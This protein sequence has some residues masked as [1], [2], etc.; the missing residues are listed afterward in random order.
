MT[1]NESGHCMYDNASGKPIAIFI[2][3]RNTS[4][5]ECSSSFS[6]FLLLINTENAMI[7]KQIVTTIGSCRAIHIL[8]GHC[9]QVLNC[10]KCPELQT[11]QSGPSY[12]FVHSVS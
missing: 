5:K 11:A 4:I 1:C 6:L 8:D 12:P 9:L 7:I 3:Q 10:L 2:L